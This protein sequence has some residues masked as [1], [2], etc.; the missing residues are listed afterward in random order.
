MK[1]SSM[2]SLRIKKKTVIPL[3]IRT[4]IRKKRAFLFMKII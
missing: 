2:G 4:Q 3:E 1:L